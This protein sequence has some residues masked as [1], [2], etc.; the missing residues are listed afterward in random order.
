LLG[1]IAIG[2]VMG[3]TVAIVAGALAIRATFR[4]PTVEALRP[5]GAAAGDEHVRGWFAVAGLAGIAGGAGLGLLPLDVHPSAL[6][7]AIDA[8]DAAGI[9]GA[10]A[11]AA[12]L[13]VGMGRL[14]HRL[15]SRSRHVPLH[16]AAIHLPLSPRRGGATVAT[17]AAALAITSALA[18]LIESFRGAWLDWIEQ[19]FAADLLVGSGARVRLLTGPA[20]APG[21]ADAIRSIDGVASVEPFRVL[22]IQLGDR[23]IFLQGISIPDRL[24]RGGLPMVEG[25]LER[26]AADL[27]AGTAVL[28]SDN[29]AFKLGLH[30]GDHIVLPSPSGALRLRIAGTFVDFLGSPRCGGRRR[31]RA[32]HSLAR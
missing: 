29:L 20:M 30:A 9:I 8:V 3:V 22:S 4:S 15:T 6:V 28:L 11:V 18:V 14:A 12:P 13:V 10:A 5:V 19:H 31:R 24:Q 21:V 32:A 1:E 25:T 2:T 16:L 7:A 17:I 26:A 23:P 27:E